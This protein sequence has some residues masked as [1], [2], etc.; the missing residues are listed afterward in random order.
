[1]HPF[2][3]RRQRDL[4]RQVVALDPDDPLRFE[5]GA[6]VADGAAELRDARDA[7]DRLPRLDVLRQKLRF[8]ERPDEQRDADRGEKSGSIGWRKC[9]KSLA[10]GSKRLTRTSVDTRRCSD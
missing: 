10:K 6:Q 2:R 5:G 8:G 9:E 3:L 7:D 4:L 1:M